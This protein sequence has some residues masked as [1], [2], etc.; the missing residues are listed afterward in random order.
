MADD[1]FKAIGATLASWR[2]VE[3]RFAMVKP[4]E[5]ES[6]TYDDA[7]L[8]VVFGISRKSVNFTLR[9]KTES[10]LKIDWNQWAYVDVEGKSH[11]VLH[12]AIAYKDKE[13]SLPP[14]SVPPTAALED[15]IMPTDYVAWSNLEGGFLALELL[16]YSPAASTFIGKTVS[17]FMPIEVNGNVKNYLFSFKVKDAQ[18]ASQ[19]IR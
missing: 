8:N 12:K 4:T 9:N 5:N 19:P 11:K 18:I 16:P 13:T 10:P 6:L 2:P 7:T 15:L 3:Y 17:V 1:L 14:S